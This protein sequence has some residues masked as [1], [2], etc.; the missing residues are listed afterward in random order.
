MVNAFFVAAEFSIVGVPKAAIDARAARGNRVARLVLRVLDDPHRRDL[1]VAT[2]Q[3][4]ITVASLGLG[5]YGEHALAG[6]ILA[7][8]GPGGWGG[9]PAAHRVPRAAPGAGLTHLPT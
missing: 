4:G 5:M 2:A 1:Y 6:G 9:W 3:I 7:R 8:L